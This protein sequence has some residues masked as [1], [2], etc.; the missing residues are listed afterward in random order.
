LRK[1]EDDGVLSFF[2]A[3][4]TVSGGDRREGEITTSV[5]DYGAIQEA[6]RM[7]RQR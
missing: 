3:G 7:Q 2:Y 5:A 4:E 1:W 6:E